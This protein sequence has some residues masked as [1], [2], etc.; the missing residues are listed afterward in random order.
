MLTVWM[1]YQI[2]LY[3]RLVPANYVDVLGRNSTV[4]SD[5]K[6]LNGALEVDQTD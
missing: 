3:C 4:A 2:Y 5:R 6:L 1:Y